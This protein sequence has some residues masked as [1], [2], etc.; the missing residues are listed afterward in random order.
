S[1][2]SA[3]DGSTS[4][5]TSSSSTTPAGQPTS[6]SR[7]HRKSSVPAGEIAGIVLGAV[8][9]LVMLVALVTWWW[10]V[11]R[12]TRDRARTT[13]EDDN[14]TALQSSK[15][16]Q[17]EPSLSS[18]KA[19]I[20]RHAY[21]T[22]SP[23]T[24][25][26]LSLLHGEGSELEAGGFGGGG[27]EGVLHVHGRPAANSLAVE[28]PTPQPF[29][30]F[31]LNFD[32][33]PVQVLR[34]LSV[35]PPPQP[36]RT[37]GAETKAPEGPG[38]GGRT[39][40]VVA[41][42]PAELS[43][44]TA[45][46]ETRGLRGLG[47]QAQDH[48]RPRLVTESPRDVDPD[49]KLGEDGDVGGQ[50]AVLGARTRLTIIES[51]AGVRLAGGPPGL[52]PLDTDCTMITTLPPPYR[53]YDMLQ[54]FHGITETSVE[55]VEGGEVGQCVVIAK[56][57]DS[58][59]ESAETDNIPVAPASGSCD[60]H[61]HEHSLPHNDQH[62]DL[63]VFT[64]QYKHVYQ[65]IREGH[66]DAATAV[67]ELAFSNRD[68][69]IISITT[70]ISAGQHFHL[71]DVVHQWF[72][73]NE[74][75]IPSSS[76]VSTSLSPSSSLAF[77]SP[78]PTGFAKHS[79]SPGAKAAIAIAVI[80]LVAG[81]VALAF[82]LRRRAAHGRKTVRSSGER[83]DLQETCPLLAELDLPGRAVVAQRAWAGS[84]PPWASG[85]ASA[86][87]SDNDYDVLVIERPPPR[88]TDA[89]A[90]GWQSDAPATATTTTTS[91]GRPSLLSATTRSNNP[92]DRFVD[93]PIDPLLLRRGST[94]PSSHVL[95][96]T[97]ATSDWA[98]FYDML[99]VEA[100]SHIRAGRLTGT[101]ID[102]AVDTASERAE[103]DELSDTGTM[104]TLP[105]PY[106]HHSV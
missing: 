67:D 49:A 33:R 46:S 12:R 50:G 80:V 55:W 35:F 22:V 42:S 17:H 10:V 56:V 30:N 103:W 91:A 90:S 6:S 31:N 53:H 106:H 57:L 1:S 60:I 87:T 94:R 9:I 102:S 105:P 98:S 65:S 40:A 16:T 58:T 11:R 47:L 78:P 61:D 69:S 100:A 68:L 15:S 7:P 41:D 26:P 38:W 29:D 77:P 18:G 62:I 4:G 97:N 82:W 99:D 89:Q 86:F 39:T 104:R 25:A 43:P 85:Q 92:D 83:A 24:T 93:S 14:Y 5:P 64:S 73:N 21:S 37:N 3:T 48:L 8:A 72:S 20:R 2:S 59:G 44:T 70:I 81:L 36:L 51:D 28:P 13:P 19:A 32:Q 95:P 66:A 54:D 34:P 23:T 79:L 84:S 74:H 52:T 63:D 75:R 76:R 27:G 71:V 45:G 101:E 96:T 88:S